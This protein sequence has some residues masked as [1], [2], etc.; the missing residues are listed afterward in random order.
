MK[1]TGFIKKIDE[2][3]RIVIPK[4]VRKALDVEVGDGL[5]FFLEDGA[6]VLKKLSVGCVFCGSETDLKELNEKH[7]CCECIKKLG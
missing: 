5:Q 4:S 1:A 2:M 6:V 7:I 3:G